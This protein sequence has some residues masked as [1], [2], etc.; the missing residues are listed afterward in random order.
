MV[1][2]VA[3]ANDQAA[4]VGVEPVAMGLN[5]RRDLVLDSRREHLRCA[6][7]RRI[8][9][10]MSLGRVAKAGVFVVFCSMWR[11]LSLLETGE[12]IR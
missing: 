10:R 6:P 4:A 11:V 2:A 9:V 12:S 1:T 7:L 5:V 8:S 3:V